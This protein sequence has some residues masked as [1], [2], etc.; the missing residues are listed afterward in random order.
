MEGKIASF[1]GKR[2]GDFM[3]DMVTKALGGKVEDKDEGK[4]GIFSLFGGDKDKGKKDEEE[5]GLFSF[6][7]DEKKEEDGGFFSKIF[8]KDG[9]DD[10]R[11]KKSGFHGLFNEM[12]GAGAA[13][14]CEIPGGHAGQSVAVSDGD[15]FDDLMDVAQETAKK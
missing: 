5:G 8:N 1:I 10:D 13:G 2:A 7:K 4:D 9:N 3:E 12:E 14:G 11:P 6:G 15:L